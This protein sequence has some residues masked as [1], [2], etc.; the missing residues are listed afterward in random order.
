MKSVRRVIASSLLLLGTTAASPASP[1]GHTKRANTF[2]YVIV[3]GGTAGLVLA[4]RLS[5]DGV[6]FERLVMQRAQD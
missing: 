3:G 1:G 2:D 4:D 6:C 5:A